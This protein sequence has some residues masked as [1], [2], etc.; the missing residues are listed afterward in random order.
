M[1]RLHLLPLKQMACLTNFLSENKKSTKATRL[2][3]RETNVNY[4][5]NLLLSEITILH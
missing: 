3:P 4:D 2:H 1:F 5:Y